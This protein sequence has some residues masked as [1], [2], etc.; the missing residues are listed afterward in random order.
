[1]KLEHVTL[2]K[3]T[4]S[5]ITFVNNI[6]GNSITQLDLSVEL[7]NNLDVNDDNSIISK[8]NCKVHDKNNKETFIISIELIGIFD[9]Q[10]PLDV[11]NDKISSFTTMI[12]FPYVQSYIAT[13]TAVAG[14][15]PLYLPNLPVTVKPVE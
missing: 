14:I 11:T 15:P 2:R 6:E 4:I 10:E 3:T 9:I 8:L 13:M 1:M 5:K 12:L 7:D